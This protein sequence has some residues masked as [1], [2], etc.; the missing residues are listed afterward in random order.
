MKRSQAGFSLIAAA[1]LLAGNSALA[2]FWGYFSGYYAPADWTSQEYNNTTYQNTASVSS[3]YVP[4]SLVIDGAVG[5]GSTA[6]LPVSIIDYTT[7]LSGTGLQPVVFH[8]LFTGAADGNDA[9][10]LIYNNGS[11]VQVIANLSAAIGIEQTYIGQL[12]GGGTFGFQVDSNNENSADTLTICPVPEP[13]T[14][15]FLGLGVSALWWNLRRR[16]S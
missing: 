2:Q 4:T 3:S 6:H 8:Y 9:A 15:T 5:A 13:S 10:Q 7:V 12:Q 16:L 11:G 14:L 1:L